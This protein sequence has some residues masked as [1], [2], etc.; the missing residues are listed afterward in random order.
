MKSNLFIMKKY[1]AIAA[2]AALLT[3]CQ[4]SDIDVN[5]P[6]QTPQ[7]ELLAINLS[8]GV[9]TK[10]TDN[11]FE[12]GDKVGVYVANNPASLQ[13]SGN[14]YDNIL[15][16]Y[17]AGWTP[18][19]KMYW[20]DKSTPADFYCYY[21]YAQVSSVTAHPFTVAADQSLLSALKA[22]D[23]SWGKAEDVLPTNE[24][25]NI[26]A[27]HIM[28]S[29][30]IILEPGD[31]FTA[32]TFAAA[33]VKVNV[34]NVKTASTVNLSTGV[35]TATGSAAQMTPY[36]DNGFYRAVVVPQ[37]VAD[38]SELI[39]VTVDGTE[40]SLSRGMTFKPG[41]RHKFTVMVN[42]TGSG[43]NVGIG[44]WEEDEEDYGGSA[45]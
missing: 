42:K 8:V 31:G 29:I 4:V 14:H 41:K 37:T 6:E 23:F 1:F 36:K 16:T 39:V 22:S 38:G 7:D 3:A 25:V 20:M 27:K 2:S 17:S 18:Q 34:R 43:V 35:V 11:A 12:T 13:N 45:E 10:V 9:S 40:Y 24:V 5:A 26:Q 32:E 28:S 30:K 21:P 33:D 44:G 19:E 15:H